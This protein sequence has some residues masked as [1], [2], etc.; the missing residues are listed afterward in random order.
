[1]KV[2][3]SPTGSVLVFDPNGSASF[4]ALDGTSHPQGVVAEVLDR[5]VSVQMAAALTAVKV[6]IADAEKISLANGAAP[7]AVGIPFGTGGV[8]AY[9]ER[10]DFLRD[11]KFIVK[12]VADAKDG[13]IVTVKRSGRGFMLDVP[14]DALPNR[15]AGLAIGVR[16]AVGPNV[17]P[18]ALMNAHGTVV[19]V[20]GV[21]A[22]VE[23]DAGDIDRVNRATG[24]RFGTV[25]KMHKTTLEV[26][27]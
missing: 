10:R 24:K 26:I 8:F 2:L 21:K 27:A 12:C 18:K 6:A 16:V 19:S 7:H 20:N 23:F 22:D 3:T 1:M 17:S 5:E 4:T 13:T 25:V 11:V 14:K 9:S 15:Q